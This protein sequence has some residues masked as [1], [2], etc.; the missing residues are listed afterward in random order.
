M[1]SNET[2]DSPV[3]SNCLSVASPA[4]EIVYTKSLLLY[5]E[6]NERQKTPY[7]GD[8]VIFKNL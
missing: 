6:L 4:L 8:E 1:I 2:A 7:A 5:I 3:L